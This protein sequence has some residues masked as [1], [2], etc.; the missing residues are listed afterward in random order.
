MEIA[1]AASILSSICLALM[2]VTDRLMVGDCYESNSN[3]AWFVSSAAGSL[4]GIILTL[5]VSFGMILANQIT[6]SQLLNEIVAIFWWQGLAMIGIGA[7]AIQ[8]L[9]HYFR[10]FA[11]EAHAA[12]IASWLAATP[13]FVYLGMLLI[14]ALFGDIETITDYLQLPLFLG[15]VLATAGLVLFERLTSGKGAGTGKYKRDLLLMILC[16]VIYI[17]GVKAVFEHTESG[18][19]FTNVL[20]LMLF[21]WI[22]FA[23]GIRVLWRRERRSDFIVNWQKKIRHY[24]LPILF[25]EIIGMLVFWFEF[26]GLTELEPT[27]VSIIVGANIFLVYLMDI[28]LG[29]L[30]QKLEKSAS[31]EII[32]F[33]IHLATANLPIIQNKITHLTLE[34]GAIL[35]TTI[36]ISLASMYMTI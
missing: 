1:L 30:R 13:I 2:V 25:V 9:L 22:G 11:E 19:S 18:T 28:G 26:L 10:C 33:D 15:V 17:V 12:S 27:F 23:A 34:V 8:L 3:H 24:V 4:F 5:L 14:T 21:Y 16:N 6:L 32:F 20:A 36:G 29:I 31:K 35:I 7:V